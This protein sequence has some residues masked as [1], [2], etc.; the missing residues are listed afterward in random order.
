[1]QKDIVPAKPIVLSDEEYE[2]VMGMF[3]KRGVD[4]I[5]NTIKR[6]RPKKEEMGEKLD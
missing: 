5:G 6:G 4:S 3:R 2:R 1:M